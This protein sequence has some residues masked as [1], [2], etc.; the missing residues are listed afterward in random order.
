MTESTRRH[1]EL[2]TRDWFC[3]NQ[4]KALEKVA[5]T[6]VTPCCF[7]LR[8]G[9]PSATAVAR[10]SPHQRRSPPSHALA[11]GLDKN[12][13][14]GG[15]SRPWCPRLQTPRRTCRCTPSN[16]WRAANGLALHLRPRLRLQV[17]QG[18]RRLQTSRSPKWCSSVNT[19]TFESTITATFSTPMTNHTPYPLEV[20]ARRSSGICIP[21]RPRPRPIAPVSG[22]ETRGLSGVS[23]TL[24]SAPMTETIRQHYHLITRQ[25]FD[26]AANKSLEARAAKSG[27]D[28]PLWVESHEAGARNWFARKGSVGAL[29]C[30]EPSLGRLPSSSTTRRNW[31]AAHQRTWKSLTARSRASCPSPGGFSSCT[32]EL[33]PRVRD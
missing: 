20:Q 29:L 8:N 12:Q 24:T 27:Y 7:G 9:P 17:V 22:K 18:Y 3:P 31:R 26:E 5:P 13:F 23:S 6:A 14:W 21:P 28:L 32:D 33:D 11:P 16:V 30:L 25:T 10:Q 19:A 15:T 2:I 4:N 1:C